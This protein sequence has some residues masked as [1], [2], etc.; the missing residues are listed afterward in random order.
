MQRVKARCGM[1]LPVT[2]DTVVYYRDS[3]YL[4]TVF[5]LLTDT[6]IFTRD[7]VT[8]QVIRDTV[9]KKTFVTI[10]QPPILKP[11]PVKITVPV[12]ADA[13]WGNLFRMF[14][15]LVSRFNF[16]FP[17]LLIFGVFI[18]GIKFLQINRDK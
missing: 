1:V 9:M 5:D 17:L 2:I 15:Q 11:V 16:W 10:T 6:L 4:D 14:W 18:I 3:I 7:S 8:V 12:A 13:T